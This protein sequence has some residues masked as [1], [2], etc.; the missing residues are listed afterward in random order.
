ML[1]TWRLRL[2]AS[3]GVLAA[4]LLAFPPA[5][6]AAEGKSGVA[7]VIAILDI[8]RVMQESLAAK[9]VRAQAQKYEKSFVEQD[10]KAKA[11]LRA[12]QQNLEKERKT[13]SQ[14]SFA[15]KARA[16]DTNV[17]EAQRKSFLRRQAF[18]RSVNTAMAK[19][20]EGM[21]KATDEVATTH[22]ITVV[23]VKQTVVLFDPKLDITKDVLADMDKTA[24]HVDFPVPQISREQAG[25]EPQERGMTQPMPSGG[26][27]LNLNP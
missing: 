21:I 10:N 4:L 6:R 19:V 2:L 22:G 16:F 12:A 20:Q 27:N 14:A 17:R 24:P 15:A 8:N 1:A 25:G 7:P 18:D 3:G 9:S 23:L 26:L 13:L 5:A 11:E